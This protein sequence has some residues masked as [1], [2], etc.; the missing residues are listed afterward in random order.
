MRPGLL[1]A[2]LLV[3]LPGCCRSPWAAYPMPVPPDHSCSTGGST[4]GDDVYVWDC[5]RG[6]RVVVSQYSSEMMCSGAESDSAPCGQQTA[7]ERKLGLAAGA[8]TRGARPGREW[9]TR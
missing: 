9:Q 3:A 7:L 6:R 1:A 2:L 4:H 5:Y 8:C